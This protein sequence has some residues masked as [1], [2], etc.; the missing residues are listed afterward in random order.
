MNPAKCFFITDKDGAAVRKIAYRT[1]MPPPFKKEKM[2]K[3]ESN[4][5]PQDAAVVIRQPFRAD[6][7]RAEEIIKSTEAVLNKTNFGSKARDKLAIARG[8]LYDA[9]FALEECI[10]GQSSEC[11]IESVQV[12]IDNITKAIEDTKDPNGKE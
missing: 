3:E 4:N 2:K 11:S 8:A 5:F 10:A 1:Y 7:K 12:V 6:Q 9:L